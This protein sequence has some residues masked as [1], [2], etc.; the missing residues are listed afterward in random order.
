MPRLK[1]IK[2]G[3][4]ATYIPTGV[5]GMVTHS[6]ILLG[7]V[8]MYIFQ[9][10]G[11]NAETGQPLKG[12][13]AAKESFAGYEEMD[14]PSHVDLALLGSTAKDEASGFTGTIITLALHINGCVHAEVQPPGSNP[15]GGE[16][17]DSCDF[18]LRRLSGEKIKPMTPEAKAVS[19]KDRPSP[20][21]MPARRLPKAVAGGLAS[22]GFH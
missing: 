18:D 11:L 12:L 8:V 2:P 1:I 22:K 9:P 19:E 10:N 20:A 15:K 13:W 16:K 6:Q 21:P 17:Y 7:D 3:S 14:L 4:F 5:Y